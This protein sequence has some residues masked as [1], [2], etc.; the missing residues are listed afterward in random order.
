MP[1]EDRPLESDIDEVSARLTDA[2]KTCRSVV[3]NYKAL[4]ATDQTPAES[5]GLPPSDQAESIE[6]P[7]PDSPGTEEH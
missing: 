4:L 6:I 5:S 1:G 3:A 2:L 7:A